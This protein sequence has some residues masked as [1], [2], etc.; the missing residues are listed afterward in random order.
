M[1]GNLIR[2]SI[3]T[4]GNIMFEK[5]AI[6][7]N[8]GIGAISKLNCTRFATFTGMPVFYSENDKILN[9]QIFT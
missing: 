7:S 1:F 9:E 4:N 8:C 3:H 2:S 6:T 5:F